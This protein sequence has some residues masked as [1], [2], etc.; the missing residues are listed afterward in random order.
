MWKDVDTSEI[1]PIFGLIIDILLIKLDEPYFVCE[2]L[3]TEEF[4]SRFHS[5]VVQRPKLIPIAF[6]KP[7][8]LLDH[9]TLGVY[10]LR[11]FHDAHTTY[12]IVPQYNSM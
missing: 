4:S 7:D 11:L 2:L 6:C 5:F 12:Y 9:H 1:I 8:E 10:S 3:E